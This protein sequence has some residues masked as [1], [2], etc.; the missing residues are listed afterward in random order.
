VTRARR[1][2]GE[3]FSALQV[4]NYRLFF[5]GQ[6]ISGTGTWMQTVAQAWLVLR[7]TNSGVAL[8]LVTALQFLPML[9]VGPLAGVIVDRADKR[10]V[11]LISQAVAGSLALVLG[12][13]V[14]TDAVQLWMVYGLALCLGM[15]SAFDMPARQTLVFE[16]VGSDRLH[17]AVS[18]NS[19]VMNGG[20]L[21]GPALGGVIIATMGLAVCFLVNAVTYLGV[22]A[23]LVRM[24]PEEFHPSEVA[25]RAKGQLREGFRYVWRT[26]ALRTP[27]LLMAAVGTLAY[28][29]QVSLPLLAKFTFGSG[30]EGYGLLLS[31]MS[32]GAVIGGLGLASRLAP[33]HSRLGRAGLAFG[34]TIVVAA[35]MPTLATTAMVMPFLGAAS[36]V[37]ITQ[38]NANLQLTALP[39]MRARVIAL[40]GVAFLGS[41][42][43]GGP[44]VGWVGEVLGGRA[45]LLLGGIATLAA[46]MAAWRSLATAIEARQ[47]A[48]A[49]PLHEDRPRSLRV[50]AEGP[51][52]PRPAVGAA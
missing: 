27:L 13:L 6:I 33:S 18:L 31:A 23:A 8:G 45:A 7:L 35:L 19:I 48:P 12:L 16:M 10:R 25:T 36:I 41:T 20:R 32:L 43:I 9:V 17:N 52:H 14:V 26:P 24:R 34:A 38:S 47:P 1:V 42:F 39:T 4:R 28:E 2:A 46:S 51:R 50:G 29:F 11:L 22:I 37:F 44:I 3:T 40:Y 30:A 15:V 5:T 21:A 49:I